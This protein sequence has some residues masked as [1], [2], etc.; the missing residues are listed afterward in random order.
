MKQVTNIQA[1]KYVAPAVDTFSME[2]EPIMNGS[3]GTTEGIGNESNSISRR[4]SSRFD[5]E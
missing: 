2:V 3:G 1:K 4:R 5:E